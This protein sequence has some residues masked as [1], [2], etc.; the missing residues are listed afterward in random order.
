MLEKSRSSGL[1]FAARRTWDKRAANRH[2][3]RCVTYRSRACFNFQQRDCNGRLLRTADGDRALHFGEK[4]DV[5][6]TVHL[7]QNK[8]ATT[9]RAAPTAATRFL[10]PRGPP[11]P[12]GARRGAR[13][14]THLAANTIHKPRR[15]NARE[16]PMPRAGISKIQKKRRRKQRPRPKMARNVKICCMG[17]GYVAGRPW[18]SSRRCAPIKVT[19]VYPPRRLL[20]CGTR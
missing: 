18:P 16:T 13:A 5:R 6:G 2:P 7:M 15:P 8:R 14:Q 3:A 20:T 11:R 17:A 4:S 12:R 9:T 19:V 1:H 10:R